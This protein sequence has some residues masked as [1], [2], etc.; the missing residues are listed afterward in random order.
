MNDRLL[1]A[2]NCE[3]Y[4]SPPPIWVMRQAGRYMPEYMDLRKQHSLL[5]LFHTP[6]LAAEVT[7]LPIDAFAPD[8]A[9]LFSDIL[10]IVEALGL[11]LEFKEKQGPVIGSPLSSESDIS[12]LPKVDLEDSLSF[13]YD[14][15]HLLKPKLNVPLLGFSGAPFTLAS[16]MIEGGSSRDLKKTLKLAYDAPEVL[17]RLLDLLTDYVIKHLQLQV[18]A[19]V[20]A[21]QVFDSW[22]NHL[23]PELFE[24]FVSPYMARIID[25]LKAINVPHII[26]CRGTAA[27]VDQ[28]IELQPSAISIDWSC[29]L[30]TFR[31][32]CPSSIAIQGN[33]HPSVLSGSHQTIEKEVKRLVKAMEG[34]PGYIFN[35]GHG[36]TPDIPYENMRFLIDTVKSL[37]PAK[38]LSSLTRS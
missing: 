13:V 32:R 15:I 24:S 20:N 6:E 23:S 21:V 17:H 14:T 22:A 28:L 3:N 29:K 33:M 19:G 37:R 2:L 10:V 30:S 38:Q 7:M 5:N 36:I 34:H 1:R 25:S 12:N 16:Y 27:F 35:L 4:D 31:A 18:K 26:F 11:G 9:I 8:A